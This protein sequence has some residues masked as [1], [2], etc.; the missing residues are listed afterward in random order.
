[1]SESQIMAALAKANEVRLGRA[2]IK[3]GLADGSLGMAEALERDEAQDMTIVKLLR[4][5]PRWGEARSYKLMDHLGL[6]PHARVRDLSQRRRAVL[7]HAVEERREARRQAL[8]REQARAS[9]SL[10]A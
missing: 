8:A 6:S 9:R 3:E 4:S 1:M 10:A 5:F 2:R 7:A